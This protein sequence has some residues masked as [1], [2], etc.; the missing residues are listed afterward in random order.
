M[1]VADEA[2]RILDTAP[3]VRGVG[4]RG[5]PAFDPAGGPNGGGARRGCKVWTAY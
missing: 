1:R 4:R 2:R 3:G 5:G